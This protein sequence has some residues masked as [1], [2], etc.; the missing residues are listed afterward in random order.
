MNVRTFIRKVKGRIRKAEPLP[1]YN[2]RQVAVLPV[3]GAA[4]SVEKALNSRCTS[5]N[6]ADTSIGHWGMFEATKKLSP[7][8]ILKITSLARTPRLTDC[9]C[10]IRAENNVLSFIVDSRARGVQRDR[11]MIE[12]GMQ[13][14]AVSLICA[15]SGVGTVL[16][17]VR[18]E[19]KRLS[20]KETCTIKLRLDPM[21]PSYNGSFW[22]TA[23]PGKERAWRHGNLPDPRRDGTVPFFSALESVSLEKTSGKTLAPEDVGQVLWAA[24]G[25][26]PHF[27][28]SIPWG[29]TIPTWNGTIEVTSVYLCDERGLFK[30]S[31]W[32][33]SRP[34]HS[35]RKITEQDEPLFKRLSSDFQGRRTFMLF[36]NNF[37]S[38]GSFWEIGY[39]LINVLL[40]L[41]ALQVS[42]TASVAA[43]ENPSTH[44]SAAL[45]HA[46]VILAM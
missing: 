32:K 17:S 10:E 2:Q 29:M 40:Q 20:D 3:E 43:E 33:N 13:Q 1:P 45:G 4:V 31:N 34:T 5:D 9:Q 26:T 38:N 36:K 28:K 37:P 8:Q 35:I 23:A 18:P 30:Y 27:Y 25:R 15:A 19:Y 24:K 16:T 22:T 41:S 46:P 7:D 11:L 6:V 44:A 21:M 39:C 42:Y 12:S 14:Q